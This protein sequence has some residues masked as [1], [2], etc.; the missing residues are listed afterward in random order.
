M[1]RN[2]APPPRPP[3]STPPASAS[4]PFVHTPVLLDQVL[5]LV[6][7]GA[8]LAV[9]ATAGGGGHA[10]GLLTR[11]PGLSLAAFD[12]DPEA[13]EAARARLV[14]FGERVRVKHGSFTQLGR[15]VVAGTVDFL[16]ADLG[17][18]SPQVDQ[19]ER[20][21][22]FTRSGPLDMRMDRQTPGPTAEELVNQWDEAR[23]RDVF[24][25]LG[26]EKFSARVA[27]EIIRERSRG[28][29]TTTGQ[30]AEVVARAVPMAT[31]RPGKHP[32]TRVFQALRMAVNHE[33]EQ[34]ESLLDAALGL[35]A[36][37]G[38]LAIIT[39]HSLEDRLV[40]DRFRDWEHPC[41]CP[42]D[43][44]Y[45]VCG[46]V[47]LGRRLTKKP[48]TPEEEEQAQ[49]PRARSAKLRAFEK[50][51]GHSSSQESP[52]GQGDLP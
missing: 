36:P 10:H 21:F 2:P 31:R 23:L 16:L 32:A 18:S 22:S 42:P 14:A 11:F 52:R 1:T 9:D 44:P 12:R 26:E 3:E 48:L 40:K 5:S 43:I 50:T 51:T 25:T 49:N 4:G 20:G 8:R 33:L 7:P 47:P 15:Q 35:L 38:R 37:G 39:F 28:A 29:I 24:F 46:K 27:R 30:L 45:C 34:L 17:V 6:P 13:V 19:G 41:Q